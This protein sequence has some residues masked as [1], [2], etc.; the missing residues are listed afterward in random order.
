VVTAVNGK[1][2]KTSS[3]L[4]RE[5]ARAKPGDALR[6]DVIRDGRKRVIEV[7][8]GTRPSEKELSA[9]DNTPGGRQTPGAPGAEAQRPS[10]LGMALGPIDDSA[11]RGL[12]IPP[13]VR[14]VVVMSVDQTSDAAQ[15]GLRRG[16]VI[17]RAG[18]RPVASAADLAAAVEVA[19]K[20]GRTGVFVGVYR[21]GRTSFLTLKVSG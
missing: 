4:T 8:S 5:V 3:E 6:L 20:A 13:E 16:D 17:V 2:V 15:K 12:N 10:V 11:R 21:G 9:N 14:G 7:R 1:N 18:D 19:K